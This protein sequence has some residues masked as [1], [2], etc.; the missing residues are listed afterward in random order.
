MDQLTLDSRQIIA[1]RAAMELK[2]GTVVNLGV[3]IPTLVA[4]YISSEIE[5]FLHS[6]NGMLGVGPSP[7]KAEI[8]PDIINAG[9]VPVTEKKGTSYFCSSK[10]FA[11]IRGG[12]IDTVILGA[13]QVSENGDIA[14]WAIPGKDILG[15][16]GSMDLVSGAKEVIVTTQH[17]TKNGEPKL[18]PTCIYPLT[19]KEVVHTVITEYAVFRFKDHK[20]ILEEMV[21][22]WTV[23]KIKKITPAYFHVS[24]QLRTYCS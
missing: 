9:K 7:K 11:M 15:V 24:E 1:K 19:A 10:S 18:V 21:D 23:E 5:V 22:G 8:N 16:G 3:G 6:E 12:H 20:M 2:D 4:D 13:L 17:V 14:N